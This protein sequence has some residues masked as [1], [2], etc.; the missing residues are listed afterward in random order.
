MVRDGGVA[1][2]KKGGFIINCI[3]DSFTILISVHYYY[4]EYF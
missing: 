1:C 2:F 4:Y 3:I